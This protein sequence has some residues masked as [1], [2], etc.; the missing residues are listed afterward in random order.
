MLKKAEEK[1]HANLRKGKG[2]LGWAMR[3]L[4]ANPIG[5]GSIHETHNLIAIVKRIPAQIVVALL[6]G[7]HYDIHTAQMGIEATPE[8]R[9]PQRGRVPVLFRPSHHCLHCFFR[10]RCQRCR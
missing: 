3:T 6:Y 1:H 10:S 7:A 9:L 8:G 5:A 4:H 2:P